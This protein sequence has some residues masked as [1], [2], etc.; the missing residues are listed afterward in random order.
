MYE[1]TRASQADLCLG[2][3]FRYTVG[4]WMKPFVSAVVG[5]I[6]EYRHSNLISQTRKYESSNERCTLSYARAHLL[7]AI[8]RAFPPFLFLSFFLAFKF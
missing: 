5:H 2:A 1:R 4:V 7:C 6:R 3:G 8:D